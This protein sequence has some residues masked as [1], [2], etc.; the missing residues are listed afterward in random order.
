MC[1]R[2][3]KKAES[4][5]EAKEAGGRKMRKEGVSRGRK[6]WYE[7]ITKPSRSRRKGKQEAGKCGTST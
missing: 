7:K 5:E 3:S 6:M 2:E 4:K 1:E